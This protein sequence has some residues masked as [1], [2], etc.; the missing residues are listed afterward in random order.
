MR[1]KPGEPEEIARS[2]N[3][4]E[5][6]FMERESDKTAT[7][8]TGQ[9]I[10][11][12]WFCGVLRGG[13]WLRRG[14][15][16]GWMGLAL[17]LSI[18]TL[19]GEM[20]G[21]RRY[22][23]EKPKER[24]VSETVR[25]RTTSRQPNA[26][27]LLVVLV[28]PILPGSVTVRGLDG[29]ELGRADADQENGQAEF[30]LPR[31]KSYLIEVSH[32]G[33]GTEKVSSR[34]LTGQTITRVRL[35]ARSA[36]VR[37]GDLPVGAQ[38]LVDGA[39]RAVVD[40]SGTALVTEIPPGGHRLTISHPEY[41]DFEDSFEVRAAGEEVRYPRIP[42]TRVAR[43]ELNGP[44][45]ALVMIDGALQGKIN[46]SGKLR[47]NYEIEQ[48]VER[49][50]TA[51]LV[52]FQP[53]SRR[54]MLSPGPRVIDIELSPVVTSAGVTD[55]FDRIN[56][57]NAP[58]AWQVIGDSRNKRLEV[59]G[60]IP[61]TLKDQVYRDLQAN[62]TVWFGDGQGVTWA[63]KIDG[64][65]RNYYLFHISGPSSTAMTPRRFFTYIVRDGGAPVEVGTP[66]PILAELNAKSSYTI[67]VTVRDFTIQHSIT[68]NDSGET[69][70]LG[71]WTDTSVSREKFIY[72]S[73]G[74]R[75]MGGE[76]FLVDDFNIEPLKRP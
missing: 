72:G 42:L 73:F 2:S 67:S 24:S 8:V 49:S 1:Q 45:G 46:E 34:Q 44:S 37:L 27:G 15:D 69:N 55:F 28:E 5:K 47:V 13:E 36:S 40:A 20:S 68:S 33:Y 16:I 26:R 60:E 62:F 56:Q 43:L 41:N 11:G 74:F 3:W 65:G 50:I 70:D 59:R 71:V 61:G 57:W 10:D 7:E 35:N 66:V 32:P 52:G 21:Q 19:T 63:L 38:I 17:L 29:R 6:V 9:P 75:S 48:T 39:A 25:V 30:S 23:I 54:M 12:V 4:Q 64:P 51:E 14:R 53:W 58:A 22:T 31:G 76:V 18:L